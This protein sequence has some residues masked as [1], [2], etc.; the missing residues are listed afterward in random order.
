MIARL[1]A[2]L[3]PPVF[4]MYVPTCVPKAILP[5]TPPDRV[6][7]SELWT[8]PDVNE[9]RDL[10]SGPWG[11]EYAP[12][13]DAI[14]TFV[15]PKQGGVNPGMTVRDPLG[16]K[17]RVKQPPTDGR[18]AEGPV[19]VVLSRVLSASGYHQPPVYYLPSFALERGGRVQRVPGGRFRLDVR[20]LRD[21]GE[22]SWH[23]NPFVGTRPYQGLLVI[24]LMF[25]SS[26]LKNS[27]NTLYEAAG[28]DGVERWYVVRDLGTALGST[29]RIT[30]VRND[31]AVFE[32]LAFIK[33]VRRGFV[34][35]NYHGWHQELVNGRITPADVRWASQLLGRLTDRAWDDIFRAGGYEPAVR[36]RFIRRLVARIEEG[37]TLGTDQEG[38]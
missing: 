21:T 30:P 31:P 2:M 10:F 33:G 14:Y 16:R 28:P 7:M 26:D 32:R 22:W 1:T 18:G 37:R 23:Q 4:A 17:W 20:R 34:E 13:P 29:G 24:L 11:P 36:Q 3:L 35:F 38:S 12:D 8:A 19:E 6:R 27:N 5:T 25:N 15:A 9:E